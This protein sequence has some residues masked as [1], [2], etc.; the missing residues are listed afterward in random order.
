MTDEFQS[1][2]GFFDPASIT[3]TVDPE[4]VPVMDQIN[5]L[6]VRQAASCRLA[7]K[8]AID[9]GIHRQAALNPGATQ[10]LFNHLIGNR[11]KNWL[12]LSHLISPLAEIPNGT[13]HG[14]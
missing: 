6:S 4:S 9:Q 1:T 10:T 11:R 2:F 13:C 12:T 5:S 14:L 3:R 7:A 8:N